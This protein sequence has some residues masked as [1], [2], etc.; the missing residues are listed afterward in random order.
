[1]TNRRTTGKRWLAGLLCLVLALSLLPTM[2]LAEE[3]TE[4]SSSITKQLPLAAVVQKDGLAEP[5][6]ATFTFE[7]EDGAAEKKSLASY[8]ITLPDGLSLSTTGA[9][10]FSKNVDVQIDLTKVNSENGWNSY[11]SA[12]STHYTKT[13][14]LTEK[15]DQKAGWK[16]ATQRYG[17]SLNYDDGTKQM[18]LTVHEPGN[19][20][21]FYT[22]SFTNTYT[23]Q[24][25]TREF[26]L[27]KTVEKGG[28]EAPS[29]ET[30][31]FELEDAGESKQS[32]D[33]YGITLLDAL[34]LSTDGVGTVSKTIHVQ[35]DLAKIDPEHG[36]NAYGDAGGKNIRWYSKTFLL[37]E[38]QDN[39][40]GWTYSSKTYAVSF[41]Y[42]IETGSMELLLHE[43]GNDVT[44]RSADFTNTYTY[45]REP[46]ATI[47]VNKTDALNAPL[48]GAVFALENSRGREVYTATSNSRGVVRFTDVDS[49]TYTLVEKSAPE[50]YVASD[51]TY[52]LTV[53]GSSVT[54]GRTPYSPVTFVNRKA[55]SLNRT[56]HF[57]FLVGYSDGSFG[58]GRNMT[59][60]EV[61]TMFSR[62]LTERIDTDRTYPNTFSDVP[63]SHWAANY[64]GY[65]QQFGI[66]MGFEDGSFR[67][68]APVTRAQ[69]AA[70]ASRFEKLTEGSKSFSDVPNSH[71]AAKY[72]N[73][74]ATRGWVTGY[75]DGTFKPENHI[76]RAE[77]AA[78]TC[79]LLERSA[80][81]SY[82][83]AN[84]S[85][86]PR[87]FMDLT[88]G[89]WAYWYALEA[90][91]GHDYTRSGS[92]E[93]WTRTYP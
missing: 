43:P 35:F 46:G 21:T 47:V 14:L 82:I 19:D 39:K 59:R 90:A 3:P 67:P 62:L 66:V 54:M 63:A 37:K 15:D 38:N 18:A 45:D 24:K 25:E 6:A 13:F 12:G 68:N 1:M 52:E 40:A 42:T 26:L 86:L 22:A 9:G 49:G 92:S 71:W 65:A 36:W 29:A 79:R 73:F 91:N 55:A 70:I 44:Y 56:D 30:F 87:T 85:A 83:R 7:L 64:I 88:E 41:K 76:T 32:L 81:E 5:P 57:A 16:Y 2:A 8:G 10:T 58:P 84:L 93:T 53:S 80:D 78:V 77:V 69:F 4:G 33:S 89:H 75:A 60:A 27:T 50:G 72:I 31:T 48:S 23:D 34:R 74:A 51:E 17:V 20:V 28:T 61:A 11:N